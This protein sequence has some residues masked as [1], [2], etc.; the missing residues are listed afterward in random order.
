L[1]TPAVVPEPTAHAICRQ[2]GR[3]LRVS[4]PE[5]DA[6]TLQSF[7]DRRPDG[8][9]VEGMSFSFTGICPRCREGR[10]A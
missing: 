10:S 8:W 4:I 5:A 6:A 9:S 3:I 7:V 2:C 1:G